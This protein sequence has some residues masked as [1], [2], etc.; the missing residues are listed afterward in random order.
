MS[1]K[2]TR[3]R[4][5]LPLPPPG[6]R[7]K[8]DK[9][10]ILD[11]GLVHAVNLDLIARGDGTEEILWQFLGGSLTWFY[12]A[13]AL[14]PREPE[15]FT[16]ALAILTRQLLIA[17]S[18]ADR[19]E[20]TGRVGFSGPEYQEAKEAREYMDA[21]AEVVDRHVAVKAANDSE[22]D[23]NTIAEAFRARIQASAHAAAAIISPT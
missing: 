19:F 12:V 14:Q 22:R 8:L 6:L 15:R 21:L 11:L 17:R 5:Y 18:L 10:Q 1:R 9:A 3:R 2:H 7:P 16:E 20:R 23:L 4:V 13:R